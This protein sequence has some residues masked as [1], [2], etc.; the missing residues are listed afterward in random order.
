L[1]SI[2][3]RIC[4]LACMIVRSISGLLSMFWTIG[5]FIIS[6]IISGFCIICWTCAMF[7]APKPKPIGGTPAAA[8]AGEGAADGTGPAEA[9]AGAGV[10]AGPGTREGDAAAGCSAG[11]GAGLLTR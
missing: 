9:A 1:R 10:A 6:R 7:G 4:G 3:S 11:F 5:L 8:A 2:I